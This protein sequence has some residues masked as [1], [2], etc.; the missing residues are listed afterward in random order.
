MKENKVIVVSTGGTIAMRYDPVREAVFPAVT[1][2]ELLE[3]VPPLADVCPVE[4][5]E[6]SNIPST[7]MYPQLMLELAMKVKELLKDD[8]VSGVVIT[9]GTDTLEETAYLLSLVLKTT[10]P[11]CLVGAMRSS[12]E[13][14]P[15]GPK[16]ILNAVKTA[17]SSEARG[18]G[19][20]VVLNDEIHSAVEV[21]K[22]NSSNVST[23]KS[24]FWGPLGYV[25]DDRVIFRRSPNS[26]Q[27]IDTRAIVDDVYLVKMAAGTD[28]FLVQALVD[29][30]V[31]GIVIEGMGRGNIPPK[32][33]PGIENAIKKNIPVILTTRCLGGRV[34]GVYGYEGAAKPLSEMGVI[35]GGEISGQKARIK[36]MLALSKT[37]DLKE[38]AAYFD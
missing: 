23:F 34:L 21:T 33:L 30:N 5:Y 31:N 26:L 9:H 22:T 11:V 28:D 1:G 13:V 32:V 36:L 35:L 2:K 8:F 3:A 4:V 7:H 18:K 19:V 24:P 14:S 29:K 6:F 20:L 16:N 17:A 25:D 12:A 37:K 38:I 15:D 10:K 27:R